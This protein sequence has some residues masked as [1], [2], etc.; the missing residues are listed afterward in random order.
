MKRSMLLDNEIATLQLSLK[1]R[2]HKIFK[3]KLQPRIFCE[4]DCVKD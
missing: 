3:E 4:K 2:G 1:S